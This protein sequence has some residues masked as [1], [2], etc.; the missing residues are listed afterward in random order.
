MLA[1]AIYLIDAEPAY[2]LKKPEAHV[3]P[4]NPI[5]LCTEQTAAILQLADLNDEKPASTEVSISKPTSTISAA[6]REAFAKLLY[7]EAG[8]GADPF[9]VGHTVLNRCTAWNQSLMETIS[10]KNQYM[11]YKETHP[12]TEDYL[13]MADIMLDE[14]EK[15]GKKLIDGCNRFYFVTGELGKSNK[16]YT[17]DINGRWE[18]RT[19]TTAGTY[20]ACA[21]AQAGE[22]F[23]HEVGESLQIASTK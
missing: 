22:F 21:R 18:S 20:C 11:G 5:G 3:F 17:A 13:R 1:S 12:A 2:R 9:E 8:R 19:E 23:G 15:G 4:E 10:Q 16:F 6:E 7:G 14:W